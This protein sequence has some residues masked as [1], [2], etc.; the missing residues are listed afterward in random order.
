MEN[1]TMKVFLSIVI[2]LGL[3]IGAMGQEQKVRWK[4][5]EPATQPELQ[6]FHSPIGIDLPTATT[7]QKWD[8]EFEVSH[9]F[10]PTTGSGIRDF[11]GLDGA[12]C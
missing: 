8:V 10:I 12:L 2:L 4:R 3:T 5:S 9:R 11:Y 1:P 7:L 6:L